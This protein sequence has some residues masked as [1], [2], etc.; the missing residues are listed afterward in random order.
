MMDHGQV[1]PS[2]PSQV[3]RRNSERS[4]A[5]PKISV[6]PTNMEAVS[7]RLNEEKGG[8]REDVDE[9][10]V[11]EPTYDTGAEAKR[12]NAST[13]ASMIHPL[14]QRA[15]LATTGNRL[16]SLQAL[17]MSRLNSANKPVE[18]PPLLISSVCS[19]YFVEPVC[20]CDG[21]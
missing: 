20:T 16:T 15:V 13:M 8:P 2:T 10:F 4:E 1:G 12:A 11:Q 7:V 17:A 9:R 6:E 21:E 19:G 18:S 14:M 3:S 5:K